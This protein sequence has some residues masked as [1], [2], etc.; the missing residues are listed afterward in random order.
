VYEALPSVP[1]PPCSFCLCRKTTPQVS[2]TYPFNPFQPK[3]PRGV[4]Q[5]SKSRNSCNS[6]REP[7]RAAQQKPLGFVKLLQLLQRLFKLAL[8][9]RSALLCTPCFCRTTTSLPPNTRRPLWGRDFFLEIQLTD[10]KGLTF[11][12]QALSPRCFYRLQVAALQL[13][14]YE[15][16]RY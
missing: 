13:L 1:C 15:A 4:L 5:L 6:L 3:Y 12:E 8:T 2:G 7:H 9:A 10:G 11:R 16:L 14:V